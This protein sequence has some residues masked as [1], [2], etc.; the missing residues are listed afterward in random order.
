MIKHVFQA[1]SINRAKGGAHFQDDGTGE[2]R[3]QAP[4]SALQRQEVFPRTDFGA[5]ELS[6][7]LQRALLCE[8][9]RQQN[10]LRL[11]PI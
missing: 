6:S 3:S 11:G 9:P 7:D 2:L 5:E 8:I 1:G 4:T 10:L